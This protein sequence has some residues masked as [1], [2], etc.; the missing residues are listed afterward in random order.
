MLNTAKLIF[1]TFLLAQVFQERQTIGTACH[2]YNSIWGSDLPDVTKTV[3]DNF[4]G[5]PVGTMIGCNCWCADGC[6]E[7]DFHIKCAYANP[8]ASGECDTIEHSCPW[9]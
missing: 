2:C 1:T 7:N 9:E 6:D 4:G 8:S 3:C 5:V